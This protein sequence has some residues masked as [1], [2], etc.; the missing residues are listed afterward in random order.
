MPFTIIHGDDIAEFPALADDMLRARRTQFVETLG[1]ELAVDN[2]GRE[3]DCY[4]RMNPLYVILTDDEGRHLASSRVMPTTG[5]TMIGDVFAHM[6]DGVPVSSPLIWETTRFFVAGNAPPRAASAL[7]W[8]GCALGLEAGITHYAGV[9]GAHMTRV[10]A[11][12][13]WAPEIIGRADSPEGDICAC[14]WSVDE[15]TCEGLRRRGRV[16]PAQ[17]DLSVVQPQRRVAIA[18]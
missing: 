18:A 7:M 2:A 14:L 1:W 17:H 11:A 12:C 13:G 16:D 3:T 6:T 9:T 15:K 8:A 5:P 10:F 4:D